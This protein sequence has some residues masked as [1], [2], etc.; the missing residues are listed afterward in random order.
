[1]VTINEAGSWASIISL[2]ISILTI[3]L[4]GSL[5]AK[6]IEIRRKARVRQLVSDIQTIP[7]DATP[8]SSA[9][10]SK[11]QSL[12]RNLPKGWLFL[13][14]KKSKAAWDTQKAIKDKNLSSTKESLED[15]LSYS[16]D[17]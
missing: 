8:L 9:S 13:F 17:L 12:A 4:V 6:V 11:L 10:L 14:S 1:M 5:R 3:L 16:E 2:I 7:D 15:W